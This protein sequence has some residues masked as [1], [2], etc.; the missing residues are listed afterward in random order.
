MAAPQTAPNAEF[1]DGG[2]PVANPMYL[3][4]PSSGAPI[5]SSSNPTNISGSV[6]VL[7]SPDSGVTFK[8]L[9]TAADGTLATNATLQA[10]TA[11]AGG[12]MTYQEMVARALVGSLKVLNGAQALVNNGG[13]A[14]AAIS[15]T[16][17]AG[18]AYTTVTSGKTL[19]ISHID[20]TLDYGGTTAAPLVQSATM[21]ITDGSNTKYKMIATAGSG[22]R[23]PM[24]FPNLGS[25]T[26][27][28]VKAT[29]SNLATAVGNVVVQLI[30]WEE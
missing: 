13:S 22:P 24:P 1:M 2:K 28:T 10:S 20:V 21:T 23:T 16:D 26:T 30:G 15:F 14:A 11:L 6:D 7:G 12:I 3:V 29:P 17:Q 9:K 4:D 27:L 25:G 19:Y 18:N 5:G 8:Y